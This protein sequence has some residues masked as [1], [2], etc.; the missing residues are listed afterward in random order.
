MAC[1]HPLRARLCE[2]P[3]GKFLD[4]KD[5]WGGKPLSL[6]CGR[7]IGCR[8]EKTRQWAVRLMHEAKMHDDSA[9]ITMTL[10]DL[11]GPCDKCRPP[12]GAA[13]LCT[14]T[15]QLFMKK[16]RARIAPTKVRFFLSGEYGDLGRPHYH[17]LIFGFGFPDR[18]PLTYRGGHMIYSSALLEDVWGL[19]DTE[20]GDVDFDSAAYVAKYVQKKL[21]GEKAEAYGDKKGEFA[22]MSRRPGIGKAW[23]DAYGS[24][25]YPSDEIVVHG[26]ECRPPRYYD[27]QYEM[28]NPDEFGKIREKRELHASKLEEFV[29]R[30]GSR[31]Q[32]APSRNARRLQVREV[33]AK[34]KL[35]LKEKRHA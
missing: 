10:R 7:C 21:N 1:Y 16:L 29:L 20:I 35:N 27:T 3:E 6:P 8:L 18:K 24:D 11:P 4:F 26:K 25:V 19:G 22:I 33:V 15:C 30:D 34:A 17:G 14:H 31:V 32:V 2:S 5:G 9:Y 28:E 12:H 23:L 13:S